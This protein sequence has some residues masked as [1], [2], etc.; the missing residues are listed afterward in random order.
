MPVDSQ[1]IRADIIAGSETTV[2]RM[3]TGRLYEQYIGAACMTCERHLLSMLGLERS[4]TRFQIEAAMQDANTAVKQQMWD[5]LLDFY[6][7]INPE[8]K[9]W[10]VDGKIEMSDN[11]M[12]HTLV[13]GVSVYNPTDNQRELLDIARDIR[14]S[15]YDPP[16]GPVTYIGY[17]GKRCVTKRPVRIGPM[18]Y[19]LLEKVAD[20]WN[21]IS[22]SKLQTSGVPAGNL[23]KADKYSKPARYKATKA[24]GEAECRILAAYCGG[25]VVTEVLDRNNNPNAHKEIVRSI[26]GTPHP[27]NIERAVDR[28]KIAYGGSRALQL[29][30]HYCLTGGFT[31]K[32]EDYVPRW[33]NSPRG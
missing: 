5:H 18:Y 21:A 13:H 15:K 12:V 28:N 19:L 31:Y 25:Q 27:T 1:G 16:H 23:S 30:Q 26:Y 14:T 9:A 6:Q 24:T 22:S 4:S 17:S 10:F 8:M 7:I 33:I 3:N 11:Y 32:F 20:D 29:V 2:G